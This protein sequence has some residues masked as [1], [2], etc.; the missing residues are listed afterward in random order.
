[1]PRF[2]FQTALAAMLS[3]QPADA[4]INIHKWQRAELGAG[5]TGGG[6]EKDTAEGPSGW[7]PVRSGFAEVRQAPLAGALNG[8]GMMLV[9]LHHSDNGARCPSL[10]AIAIALISP[11][12]FPRISFL[13]GRR[14][15]R[16]HQPAPVARLVCA[17]SPTPPLCLF[18]WTTMRAHIPSTGFI[19]L[20]IRCVLFLLSEASAPNH[21]LPLLA[22]SCPNHPLKHCS[23]TCGAR[24]RVTTL[25]APPHSFTCSG[26]FW[27]NH[28][29]SEF[30]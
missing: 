6:D 22:S 28:E 30:V 21:E 17:F 14:C 19:M 16:T 23:P 18:T 26:L 1:V 29:P 7:P 12:P 13:L 8:T 24:A 15:E 2:E 11:A 20:P 27:R 4:W 5:D 9:S 10:L 25:S 3:P